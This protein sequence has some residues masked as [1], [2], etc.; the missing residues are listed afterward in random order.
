[1]TTSNICWG[2]PRERGRVDHWDCWRFEHGTTF[3]MADAHPDRGGDRDS[4]EA[5]RGRYLAAKARPS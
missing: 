3:L 2:T 4:F 1:M 5:A